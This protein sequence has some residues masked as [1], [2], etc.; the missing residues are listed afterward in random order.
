VT[1]PASADSR[2]GEHFNALI[3][4]RASVWAVV[5]GAATAVLSGGAMHDVRVAL[6]GPLIV[7]LVVVFVAYRMATQRAANDFFAALAPALGLSCMVG[8]YVPS[9]PLLAA[10]DRQRFEHTMQGPLFGRA[11]GPPCLLAHYTYDTRHQTSTGGSAGVDRWTQHPFTVCAIE[12]GDGPIARYRGVFLRERLSGLGL[13]HDWLDR[14]PKPRAIELE[15]ERFNAI[16]DLRASVDQDELALRELFSPSLVDWLSEHPLHI[17]F[18]CKAG[19]LCVFVR[20]H[21]SSAGR[22]TMLHEAARELTKRLERQVAESDLTMSPAHFS[23]AGQT[24]R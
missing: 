2:R 4:S 24:I 23:A 16:Y 14:P 18:E 6:G 7:V 12:L 17:G 9:T 22:I 15:S 3:R 19:T 20:G 5:L 8:A 11:G 1:A 21:E 13:D 10:G